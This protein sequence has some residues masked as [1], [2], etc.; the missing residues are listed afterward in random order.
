MQ[1]N[2]QHFIDEE[3]V[4]IN[5]ASRLTGLKERT[6]YNLRHI[7]KGPKSEKRG[8]KVVYQVGEIRKW[9]KLQAM[10]GGKR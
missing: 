1:V 3:Y 8:R 7:R 10:T 5:I 6:L 9:N 4:D 2:K